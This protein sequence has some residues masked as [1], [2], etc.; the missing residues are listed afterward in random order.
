MSLISA[1][2]VSKPGEDGFNGFVN[3]LAGNLEE[4]GV[5]ATA[6]TSQVFLGLQIQCTQCHNHP[7]NDWKQSQFWELNAF[8]R[9]T[10]ALRRFDRDRPADRVG[11]ANQPGLRRRGRCPAKRLYSLSCETDW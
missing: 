8:F 6:K 3:F 5:Q 11:R 9:Q 10:R 1:K 7:F 2:G 4:K